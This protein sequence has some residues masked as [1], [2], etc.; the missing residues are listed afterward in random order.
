MAAQP[1]L[2]NSTFKTIE[3]EEAFARGIDLHVFNHG[4]GDFPALLR[5]VFPGNDQL[6]E[7]RGP[8]LT[9]FN[10]KTQA[11]ANVGIV[12]TQR[13]NEILMKCAGGTP[14]VRKK[15]TFVPLLPLCDALFLYRCNLCT[16]HEMSVP[17]NPRRRTSFPPAFA[18]VGKIRSRFG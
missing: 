9:K 5:N 16:G 15:A 11:G 2:H 3:N 1:A 12:W 7:I 17:L 18:I 14:S 6:V 8:D 13:P 10:I 4:S